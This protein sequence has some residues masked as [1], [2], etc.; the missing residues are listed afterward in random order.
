MPKNR[1]MQEK[2]SALLIRIRYECGWREERWRLVMRLTYS[3]LVLV[4]V[5]HSRGVEGSTHRH[6]IVQVLALDIDFVTGRRPAQ[7]K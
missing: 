6:P 7:L 5:G 2:M 1:Y 3:H 4:F